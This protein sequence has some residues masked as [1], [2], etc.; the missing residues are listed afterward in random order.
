MK[1]EKIKSLFHY[2]RRFI[3]LPSVKKIVLIQIVVVALIIR[4]A[5]S[6]FSLQQIVQTLQRLSSRKSSGKPFDQED[7]LYAT[8]VIGRRL[9][10]ATCLVNGLAG[11][12]LLSR[13]GCIST[14]HIGVKKETDKVLMAHAWVT[15]DKQVVIG[16]IDDLDTYTPLP[17]IG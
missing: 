7:I 15:V 9:P 14:L 2:C 17:G 8:A 12:Y 4:S 13:N 10:L 3:S 6:L 16:M 1:F 5:L 11:Q